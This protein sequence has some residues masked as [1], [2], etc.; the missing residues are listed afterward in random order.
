MDLGSE[1]ARKGIESI[2]RNA[3]SQAKLISDLLDTTGIA[4]GKLRL[5]LRNVPIDEVVESAVAT[6]AS[7]AQAQGLRLHTSLDARPAVVSGDRMRLQQILSNLLT[8]A[9][10]YTDH[11][12]GE[13]RVRTRRADSGV[14]IEVS[15]NGQGISPSF[16]PRLFGFFQQEEMAT[17][18]RAGGLGL[19]LAIVKQLVELHQGKV[20]ADSDGEGKGSRFT[21]WLP[22][23]SAEKDAEVAVVRPDSTEPSSD[24]RGIRVLVV[25]DDSDARDLLRQMFRERGADVLVAGGAEEGVRMVEEHRPNVLV[26]DVAMPLRDGYDLVRDLRGRGFGRDRLPAIAISAFARKEDRDRAFAAGYQ[27]HFSKPIDAQKVAATIA[28]L[29]RRQG[30]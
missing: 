16:L 1:E 21:V 18:R 10:K 9:M 19:G 22:L 17:T 30:E 28:A 3:Q 5:E 15:D 12:D 11:A 8:N 24:L 4:A 25:D 20:R 26:S 2:E 29:T 14:E 13:I 23:A 6:I 27:A 7:T